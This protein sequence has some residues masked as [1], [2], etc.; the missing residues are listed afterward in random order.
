[1]SQAVKISDEIIKSAKI[2]AKAENR[3]LSA[4]IEFWAKMGKAAEQNPDMP[5]SMIKAIMLA[6]EEAEQSGCEPY[7]FG[8]GA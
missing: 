2:H 3:S 4:Q 1:M 8:E 7:I 6:R 5:F